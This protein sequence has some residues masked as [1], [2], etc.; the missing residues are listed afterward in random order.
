M[1]FKELHKKYQELLIENNN[2]KEDI[3]S[4]KAKI[5][6]VKPDSIENS[7]PPVREKQEETIADS[8]FTSSSMPA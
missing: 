6:D 4:L 7:A 2:L 3:K 8:F 1:D 5:I